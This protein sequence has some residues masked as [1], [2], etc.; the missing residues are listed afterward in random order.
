[1]N[2][3]GWSGANI[4]NIDEKTKIQYQKPEILKQ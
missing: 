2:Y 1:M 3:L 4:G